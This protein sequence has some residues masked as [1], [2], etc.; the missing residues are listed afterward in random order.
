MRA[1]TLISVAFSLCFF[2]IDAAAQ[3]AKPVTDYLNI[4]GPVVFNKVAYNLSWS[5]HPAA[6]YY[7]HEYIAK[8]DIADKYKTM[9]LFDVI[10]GESN[11]K[12][13]VSAKIEELKKIKES[14]PIVNYEVFDNQKSGEYM[15]DFL[16][17]ENKPDGNINILE[18]NVYR[19]KSFTDKN[20]KKGIVLFG[21]STRSYGKDADAFLASLKSIKSILVTAVLQFNIPAINILK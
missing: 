18:R 3:K 1:S 6:Y 2:T 8:R 4:P 20:G 9:L 14:N 16:I 7:K 5:S 19:Y 11:L 21:V 17:S 13:V 15:L 10:T 12:A